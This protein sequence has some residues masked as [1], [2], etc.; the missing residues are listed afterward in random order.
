MAKQTLADTVDESEIV[1]LNEEVNAPNFL[2][3]DEYGIQGSYGDYA[4]TQRKIA[5]RTGKEEDGVN[6]GKIIKYITWVTVQPHSYGRTPFDILEN[7][8]NYVSLQKFKKLN[9]SN[10]FNDVK[11]IYID[12]QQTVRD[13][14]KSTQFTQDIKQQGTLINEINQLKEEL[15]KVRA[16]LTEAD[17][18]RELIKDKRRIIVGETEPKKHR[19]KLEE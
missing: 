9:K 11:R 7:Y 10:N 12:T 15:K 8:M 16:I 4:L 19:L 1:D 5:H 14:L 2:I 18:L 17:E 13:C 6:N 3:D